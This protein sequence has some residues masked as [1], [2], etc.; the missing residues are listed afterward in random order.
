MP[1]PSIDLG[2]G[3]IP[4]YNENDVAIALD[5]DVAITTSNYAGAT[6]TVARKDGANAQDVFSLDPA[7]PLLAFTDAGNVTYG[8][9]K[10]GTY[11][12]GSGTVA[13]TFTAA[14][15]VDSVNAVARSIE[16]KNTS[17]TLNTAGEP[18]T[19]VY[20]FSDNDAATVDATAEIAVTLMGMEDAPVVAGQVSTTV[21]ED[22][23]AKGSVLTGQLSVTD[24][25]DTTPLFDALANQPATYG[26]FSVTTDG[27]WTYTFNNDD[28]VVAAAQALDVGVETFDTFDVT[29]GGVTQTVNILVEGADDASTVIN[30]AAAA[31]GTVTEDD[32]LSA[33]GDLEATDVDSGGIAVAFK[34]VADATAATYGEWTI[35]DAGVWTY[36]LD[37]A[38]AA[39]QALKQGQSLTD[40][41]VV[42]TVDG[43]Q[44]TVTVT[45]NG[46]NDVPE[47][48]TALQAQTFD[49][50]TA[51]SF[52]LPADAFVD[53]DGDALLLQA[54]QSG[55]AVLPEWLT[56]DAA[57]RAFTGTPPAGYNGIL[58][59]EVVAFNAGG[60]V[61][62]T[63]AL[64]ITSVDDATAVTGDVA[65]SVV[66]DGVD[67]TGVATG[68]LA[69]TDADN[70]TAMN[71]TGAVAIAPAI[72][73]ATYGTWSLAADG[74]WTYDLDDN[75]VAVQELNA[76][77]TLADSFE[78]TIGGAKQVVSIAIAGAD[79]V[80][81]GTVGNDVMAGHGGNETLRGLAGDDTITGAGGN[82]VVI[83][84]EGTDR[85]VYA[86]AYADFALKAA[87]DGLTIRV[88]DGNAEGGD[89]G[90][91][92]VH[93]DVEQLVFGDGA[94]V[95]FS[96]AGGK[97]TG[98]TASKA[99]VTLASQSITYNADP[100]VQPW[101]SLAETLEGGVL[102]TREYALFNGRSITEGFENGLRVSETKVDAEGEAGAD[103]RWSK[104]VRTYDSEN[105]VETVEFVF[106][107]GAVKEKEF[108][109]GVRVS[110]TWTD[111]TGEASTSGRTSESWLYD[112]EGRLDQRTVT[113]D[114]GD[115][116][117][118]EY[119][120]GVRA[121]TT[122]NDVSDA[123][124]WATRTYTYDESGERSEPVFQ[125]DDAIA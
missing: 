105:R 91:D 109:A 90:I 110:K 29:V 17:E 82:D 6:L 1:P 95:T 117:V 92:T 33:T 122:F 121:S 27:R 124:D 45:I 11:A 57:T 47:L 113:Y 89:E 20:A 26:T 76:G 2:I 119:N 96:S 8:G 97:L 35:T 23:V 79:D 77:G 24:V 84:N 15:G 102:T 94:T 60:T 28:A 80:R 58:N 101:A 71:P 86:G 108:A 55:G 100:A 21:A 115:F 98:F 19:I 14:A 104:I 118:H 46:T 32:D 70:V 103:A 44:Q 93:A 74:V 62:D 53:R 22:S 25:D 40:S 67:S 39:V 87:A 59:L 73:V 111:A 30:A 69:A 31:V 42:E 116:V 34:A 75:N 83:G 50:D 66:E 85:A 9:V 81:E 88:T 78:L 12:I 120:A 13:V 114:D 99:G 37:D 56:F 64:T 3:L 49:E 10:V 48:A 125:P 4:Q 38:N 16:Y 18:A 61:S 72:G 52:T 5:S 112:D 68:T 41:F 65:G 123:K 107:T 51:V 54:R 36:T 63:F 7:D 43:T 106:D